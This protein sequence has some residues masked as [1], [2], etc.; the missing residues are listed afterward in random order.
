VLEL[1]NVRK[2]TISPALSRDAPY[3]GIAELY[4]DS[5]DDIRE[6]DDTEVMRRIRE[7]EREFVSE[8][9]FFVVSE[10]VQ[11]DELG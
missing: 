2:Y 5:V 3:D 7:D 8:S 9:V 1:P 10:R 4:Y 6:G 11:Y